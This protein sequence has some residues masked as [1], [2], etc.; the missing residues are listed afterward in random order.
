MEE[1]KSM[2]AVLVLNWN[3][4]RYLSECFTSLQ[5]QT[6]KDFETYLV[7]NNSQDDSVSFT[8][9]NFP[10]V[11][12]IRFEKNMEFARSYNAAAKMVKEEYL[13]F[14]NN[15]VYVKEDCMERLMERKGKAE[16]M[17]GKLL[18]YDKREIV[19]EAGIQFLPLGGGYEVGHGER[20]D[21]RFDVERYVGGVC[22][23][24]MFISRDVF[25]QLLF[26]PDFEAYF[27]DVDLCWRA[28]LA[29]KRI[30]YVP[31]AVVYHK[32]GGTYDHNSSRTIYISQRNRLQIIIKNFSLFNLAK[33]L[34]LSLAYD[35]TKILKFLVEGEFD[36]VW[37]FIESYFYVLTNIRHILRK[38]KKVQEER[39]ISDKELYLKGYI[40]SFSEAKRE[41]ERSKRIK[42]SVAQ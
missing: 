20:E 12:I 21:G 40:A 37:A 2:V 24:A 5:N 18:F 9:E 30:L 4:K 34:P 32:F 13:F 1:S 8:Q 36:T 41:Y 38:R 10:W 31:D 16:I 7:D 39:V 19:Q 14:L 6:F 42:K 27:E 3:G 29:G 22:G 26:D 35:G 33:A 28:W 17:G 23:A 11:K 15:D 25:L